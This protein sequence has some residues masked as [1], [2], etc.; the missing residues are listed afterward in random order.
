M[1]IDF[2]DSWPF[3][4]YVQDVAERD[5]DPHVDW[6]R[7][8]VRQHVHPFF[9]TFNGLQSKL[10]L[11]FYYKDRESHK[12]AQHLLNSIRSTEPKFT[13]IS[14]STSRA[15]VGV[16]FEV[17]RDLRFASVVGRTPY[18]RSRACQVLTSVFKGGPFLHTQLLIR[19]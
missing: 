2:F 17:S 3:Y 5:S 7:Q 1:E 12:G 14:S 9:P 15:K 16:A 8:I 13:Q 19:R 18:A 10:E 6:H 4:D 11:S